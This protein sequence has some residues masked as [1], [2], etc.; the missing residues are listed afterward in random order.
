MGGKISTLFVPTHQ[1]EL[2]SSFQVSIFPLWAVFQLR[3]EKMAAIPS[4]GSL[5]ATHDYYRS[6]PPHPLTHTQWLDVLWYHFMHVILCEPETQMPL[7]QGAW[8][9]PPAAA[10][11]AVQ[12]SWAKSFLTTQVSQGF[13]FWVSFFLNLNFSL[14]NAL[15]LD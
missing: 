14:P 12:S 3:S 2:S 13:F 15:L 4:S 11:A 5:I 6:E 10:P 9:P 1:H 8:A 7:F